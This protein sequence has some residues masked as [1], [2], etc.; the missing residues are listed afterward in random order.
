VSGRPQSGG[1]SPIIAPAA[2]SP[3]PLRHSLDL[4]RGFDANDIV[5]CH[6]KSN[7]HLDAAL[8]GLTDLDV[9]V[10]RRQA[11]AV[12]TVLIDLGYKRFSSLLAGAYPAVEDYLGLDPTTARLVHLHLHYELVAGEP[13]LKSYRLRLADAILAS[14]IVDVATGVH[15]THPD[16]EML[17]L[18]LRCALKLRWRD[19]LLERLGRRFVRGGL[20]REYRWLSDRIDPERVDE[21]ASIAL[22]PAAAAATRPL[23]AAAPTASRLRRLQRSVRGVLADQRS[24]GPVVALVLR[25]ARETASLVSA[26]NRRWLRW[27]IPLRRRNPVG[28]LVVALLGPDGCG[29]ST[30]TRELRGWLGWKL[31]VY[32]VY[33]GSGSGPVSLLRWPL[34]I[35]R[36]LY[37]RLVTR[38]SGGAVSDGGGARKLRWLWA[39]ALAV[40]KRSRMRS[41]ARARHRGMTVVCDRY[42][43]M[44]VMG[45][46]DGPLLAAWLDDPGFWRRRIARWEY[47]VY[48]EI[49]RQVPDLA[50]KLRV[51]PEVA[52][53]RKPE[54][55]PAE[56]RRRLRALE[57]ID[58]GRRCRHITLDADQPLE[59]V[60]RQARRAVWEHL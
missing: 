1:A 4:F 18:L 31:D 49:C 12:Q 11:R 19:R 46:N 8:A 43:Q 14:R 29:K 60:V 37:A 5:H 53:R 44:Q 54:V 50:I 52:A 34:K 3:A 27:P 24:C 10:D 9:L 41:V 47:R 33:F 40:E 28:G 51:S 22:G 38:S 45:F 35:A 17:L 6:F 2:P 23:L 58:Y 25:L 26:V 55:T 59:E 20:L 48:G 13:Y 15:V 56:V 21:A 42:P 7:Q 39:L 16:Q 32:P 57:R 36:G 30:L